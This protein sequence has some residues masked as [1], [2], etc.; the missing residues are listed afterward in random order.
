MSVIIIIII[1]TA[2]GPIKIAALCQTVTLYAIAHCSPI[3]RY[4]LPC[5][6]PNPSQC[7]VFEKP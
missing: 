2:D 6:P 4:F 1:N 3:S 7:P 5:R